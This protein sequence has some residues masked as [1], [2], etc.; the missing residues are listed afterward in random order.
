LV[1]SW[2]PNS[3]KNLSSDLHMSCVKCTHT[4]TKRERQ[5]EIHRDSKCNKNL[6]DRRKI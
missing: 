5:R 6:K 2:D 3:R 1:D 4:H